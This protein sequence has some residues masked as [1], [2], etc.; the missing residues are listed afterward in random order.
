M[1][2]TPETPD[3]SRGVIFQ[4]AIG[5]VSCAKTA[6]WKLTSLANVAFIGRV[7]GADHPVADCGTPELSDP[8]NQ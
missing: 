5:P 6:S 4:L 2:S 7:R 8:V 1:M 3:K